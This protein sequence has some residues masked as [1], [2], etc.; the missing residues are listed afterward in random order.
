MG[1]WWAGRCRAA[2]PVAGTDVLGYLWWNGLSSIAGPRDAS[3][4][5]EELERKAQHSLSL[6]SRQALGISSRRQATKPQTTAE[7]SVGCPASQILVE[8][9]T[10]HFSCLSE[11]ERR[12]LGR[13][14]RKTRAQRQ[15]AHAGAADGAPPC[16]VVFSRIPSCSVRSTRGLNYSAAGPSVREPLTRQPILRH[17]DE[18]QTIQLN[19]ST[20]IQLQSSALL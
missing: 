8:T 15:I 6:T 13:A 12:A 16:G 9:H 14:H 10:L 5:T 2:G 20:S 3:E 1:G 4:G 7:G 17:R 11:L 19:F 18:M